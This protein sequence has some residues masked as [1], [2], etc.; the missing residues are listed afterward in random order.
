[1][2]HPTTP[3]RAAGWSGSGGRGAGVRCAT[4]RS[5]DS[6]APAGAGMG[7][8]LP[9]GCASDRLSAILRF[10]R[11]YSPAP[12]R[13]AGS[14][15]RRP[16]LAPEGCRNVA[17]GGAAPRRHPVRRATRGMQ[18][19]PFP[20]RQGGGRVRV[21]GSLHPLYATSGKGLSR[22]RDLLAVADDWYSA[23]AR[24]N[25]VVECSGAMAV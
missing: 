3:P 6:S 11:G 18:T 5:N 14:K 25:E 20:P 1:V 19:F 22:R 15:Q 7:R 8:H 10:T 4:T 23:C 12:L 24:R 16:I 17:T 9:T 2:P 13:P 21:W